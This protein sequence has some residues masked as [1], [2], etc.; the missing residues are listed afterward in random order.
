[1]TR[2]FTITAALICVCSASLAS[3]QAPANPMTPN[4]RCTRR[5]T[6]SFAKPPPALQRFGFVVR[7]TLE[8]ST[9]PHHAWMWPLGF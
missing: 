5:A 9:W 3:A 6:A 4:P 7:A 1:M 2:V 8:Q